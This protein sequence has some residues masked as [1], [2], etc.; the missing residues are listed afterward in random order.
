MRQLLRMTG[1]VVRSGL[2]L[3]YGRVVLGMTFRSCPADREAKLGE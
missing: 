3:K 1:Q 2:E